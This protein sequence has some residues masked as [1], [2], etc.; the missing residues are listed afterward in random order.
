MSSINRGSDTTPYT[1][2]LQQKMTWRDVVRPDTY[3]PTRS[4]TTVIAGVSSKIYNLPMEIRT[5]SLMEL[6]WPADWQSIFGRQAP[7]IIEI[8]F[9]NGE[10]I[11]E[12]AKENPQANVIGLEI[13]R[14]SIEKAVRRLARARLQNLRL[15]QAP[16]Q[17]A[18]WLLCQHNQVQAIYLNF[19]DPWPKAGHHRR[20]IVNDRFLHLA[21]TRM[22][23]AAQLEIA[24]DHDEYATWIHNALANSPYFDSRFAAPYRTTDGRRSI[25]KYEQKA[26]SRG[27]QC[28]YFK[29]SRITGTVTD[30]FSIPKEI[31]MPHAI[32]RSTPHLNE[33]QEQF[34]AGEIKYEAT[35]I[36]FIELYA[37]QNYRT[38]VI[39]T[40]VREDW[41]DQRL[42]IMISNRKSNEYLLRTHEAG[43]PRATLGVHR[44]IYELAQW[45]SKVDSQGEILRHNLQAVDNEN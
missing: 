29:W 10:F 9:G 19:P 24:T 11:I 12:L 34:K 45:L 2:N 4:T 42:L 6:S 1:K 5:H 35:T 23:P 21:A 14:P 37:A 38:L 8:G 36:R 15:I 22:I 44:A 3:V 20:R 7:L 41:L 18:L 17:S 43:F 30:P 31:P 39:D 16:A 26:L 33:I 28:Y 27:I 32:V 40:F 13:S 25:T